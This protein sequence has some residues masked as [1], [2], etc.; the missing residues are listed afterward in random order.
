[1]NSTCSICYENILKNIVSLE[2]KHHYHLE[3]IYSL[4]EQKKSYS[5]K[6]PLCRL[7]FLNKIHLID[8]HIDMID[9]IE[10]E[11]IENKYIRRIFILLLTH[12]ICL[13][14]LFSLDI[15][16][17]ICSTMLYG[18]LTGYYFVLTVWK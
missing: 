6:C 1:M 5:N 13:L 12:F 3:C 2:C 4:I 18:F 7:E 9:M 8:D 11:E 15:H 17:H 10:F 14:L 16:L